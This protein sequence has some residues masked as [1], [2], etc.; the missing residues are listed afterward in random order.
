MHLPVPFGVPYHLMAGLVHILHNIGSKFSKQIR[1]MS[2]YLQC[3]YNVSLRISSSLAY[4]VTTNNLYT[5]LL[6][7][8]NTVNYVHM[9]NT[10]NVSLA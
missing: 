2:S 6:I 7:Q 4:A 8:L 9:I 5:T 10:T 1:Q 3:K